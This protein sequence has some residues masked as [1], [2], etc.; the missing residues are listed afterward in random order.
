M[1]RNNVQIATGIIG[2]LL[3]LILALDYGNRREVANQTAVVAFH[4]YA[5]AGPDGSIYMLIVTRSD[6]AWT[7]R[8]SRD[9]FYSVNVGDRVLLT[10]EIGPISGLVYRYG[11]FRQEG[12]PFMLNQ[13]GE[14]K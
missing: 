9:F 6:R 10:R 13:A 5:P 12:E 14:L 8:V 11:L 4:K 1:V 7:A 2:I 3:F